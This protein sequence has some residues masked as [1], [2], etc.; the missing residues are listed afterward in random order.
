MSNTAIMR[1]FVILLF[2]MVLFPLTA[3]AKDEN[4]KAE[5]LFEAL[6][7]ES[8]AR[9]PEWQAYLG[10]QKNG[11]KWDDR[12][13]KFALKSQKLR[14]K[15]LQ[16]LSKLD[17]AQLNE[18]N[19]LSLQL[20][21][22]ALQQDIDDF[23]WRH[24]NYPVNQMFGRHSNVPSFLINIHAVNNEKEARAYI[25]RLNRVKHVISQ[26]I[27][28]LD[29]RQKKGIIAPTFVFAYVR[30]DIQNI[31]TGY[32]FSE[33]KDSDLMADFRKKV[34]ALELAEKRENKLIKQAEKA[35]LKSVLPAYKGL[36]ATLN[37]LES[38]SNDTAGAWKFP[39]GEAFY[40]A[41]LK[42]TTATT[43]TANDIHD[44]GLA[45]VER[46]HSEMQKLMEKV[47]FKGD[48]NAF[49]KFMEGDK[50]FYFDNTEAG[51][52]AYLAQV[53]EIK[54]AM[55]GKLPELFNTLPK[56]DLKVKRVEP[57]R[58][59]SA[60][61]AFY[62][63][64]A[65]DGSRPGIYYVNLYDMGNMP[66][67]QMEALTY[68]EA[69][70]GHHMQL[71]IAQEIKGL[72]KFRKHGGYTAYIEGWGLYSELLPKEIGFYQDPYSDF[73]RLSMELWRAARL[74]TD[75][76]LHALKWTREEA[77]QYLL[78]NT[79]STEVN[80]T[81]AIERY[82]VMPS[83][84]TAY[85]IG[86]LKIL[87]LRAFAQ[88]SLGENFDVRQFHDVVLRNGA[89]PLDVLEA[90]VEKWVEETQSKNHMQLESLIPILTM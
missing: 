27:D 32:P 52:D 12:S 71:S 70:P 35:L 80:A 61:M 5:K 51:R 81:K 84:A 74:V 36:L 42:S 90:L 13:E 6:F 30:N 67:Y 86:M 77:I 40:N 72:P 26:L 24:H 87:E 73:G 50:Q 75:T 89:V 1:S 34:V 54:T 83:Q 16:K 3:S 9:Q 66:K 25:K 55:D 48:L 59:K 60:G 23:K 53:Q 85:K 20:Y 68:H 10:I 43:L 18:Q 46:I 57:Y 38:K 62:Q 21:Q 19:L 14:K 4:V 17:S 69:A 76:G 41:A 88:K 78:D 65:P 56:A 79:P 7:Q 22:Y 2:C 29:I 44:I 37:G 64:P 49:F 39:D 11:G 15:Q 31:I 63:S 28:D 58:E 47:D 45:D 33:G 82:I 8:V